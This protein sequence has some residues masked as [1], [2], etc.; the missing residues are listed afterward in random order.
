MGLSY[1]QTPKSTPWM[2]NDNQNM[3]GRTVKHE[4]QINL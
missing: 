1:V 3:Q 4:L 2:P